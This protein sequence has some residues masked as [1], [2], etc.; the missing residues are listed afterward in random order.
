MFL[1]YKEPCIFTHG[2]R[3]DDNP[4][5]VH[6]LAGAGDDFILDVGS[7]SDLQEDWVAQLRVVVVRHDI[8]IVCLRIFH[9]ST[10]YNR[11]QVCSVLEWDE[12]EQTR[13]C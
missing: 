9:I 1:W 4:Q 3:E 6:A 12:R 2:G 10:L 5:Y 8:Y 11:N 13:I 7:R